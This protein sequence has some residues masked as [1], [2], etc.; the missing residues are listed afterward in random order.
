MGQ[1]NKRGLQY[2]AGFG[3]LKF[4]KSRLG[5]KQGTLGAA[6]VAW[7]EKTG[8]WGGKTTEWYAKWYAKLTG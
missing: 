7:D 5:M 4:G 2:I 8:K 6:L 1:D 3:W